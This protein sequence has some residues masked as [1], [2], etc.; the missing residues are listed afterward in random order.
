MEKEKLIKKYDK[1]VDTY[2]RALN[3][4]TLARWRTELLNDAHGD[5]LEV[6]VGIGSNFQFY[7]RENVHLTGVDFSSEMIKT[8]RQTALSCQIDAELVQEDVETLQFE[9]NSFDC[10]VSTL[11]LCGYANPTRVLNHFNNWCKKDGTVLL[12]EHGISSNR[13]V[14]NTQ[15]LVDPL[16][17]K[18][19]G[20]HCNRNIID[21]VEKSNLKIERTQSH[22]SDIIRLIWAS[23]NK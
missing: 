10:I 15:K 16:F 17:V 11:T 1:Q 20:C 3:N 5:V 12:M 6:G 7:N 19:A 22:W 4:R 9:S 8:A 2:K 14:S 23:P 21:I 13:M 18:A